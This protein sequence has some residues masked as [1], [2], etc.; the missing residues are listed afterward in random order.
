MIDRLIVSRRVKDVVDFFE[1]HNENLTDKL[2]RRIW[3]SLVDILSIITND[4]IA[5]TV[6]SSH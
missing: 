3:D 6:R 2:R 1:R 4:S 5:N